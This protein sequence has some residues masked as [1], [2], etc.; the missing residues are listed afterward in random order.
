MATAVLPMPK[1]SGG[2][3]IRPRDSA[4]EMNRWTGNFPPP[5][6]YLPNVL[7]QQ[8]ELYPYQGRDTGSPW[9]KNSGAMPAGQ[10]L[11]AARGLEL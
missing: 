9:Q 7:P 11:W 8:G 6:S 5:N 1:G 10:S 3:V 2:T 4:Q